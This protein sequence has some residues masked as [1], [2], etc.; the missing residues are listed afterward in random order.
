MTNVARETDGATQMLQ[1]AY[2]TSV[3]VH[4]SRGLGDNW[5][6]ETAMGQ[7]I[8]DEGMLFDDVEQFKEAMKILIIREG[9]KVQRKKNDHEKV[10]AKCLGS[11][12]PRYIYA[13]VVPGEKTF[14]IR[15]Y[16]KEHTCGRSLDIKKMDAKWIAQQYVED[17]SGT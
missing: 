13:R 12:C 7:Y 2:E 11:G 5:F 1:E 10:S 14:R 9:R 16:V 4:R 15:K 6:N 17:L 8:L 3:F